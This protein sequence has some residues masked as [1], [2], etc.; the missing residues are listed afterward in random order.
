MTRP[1][2]VPSFEMLEQRTLRSA[3]LEGG[4]LHVTGTSRG[5]L[6]SVYY[7]ASTHSKLDVKVGRTVSQF[8]ASSVS[9]IG[10]GIRI[11]SRERKSYRGCSL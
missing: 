1:C 4:E 2:N 8:N 3:T 7:D 6:I 11:L 9:T 10:S 5:D